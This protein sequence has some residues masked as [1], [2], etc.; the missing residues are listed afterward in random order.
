MESFRRRAKLLI[1]L[2][3]SAW[4]LSKDWILDCLDDNELIYDYENY[5]LEVS[6]EDAK[7]FDNLDLD[8]V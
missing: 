3:K 5:F 4:I 1:G 8:L 7:K 6:E 2:N